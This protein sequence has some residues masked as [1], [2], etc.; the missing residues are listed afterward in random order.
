MSVMASQITSVLIIYLTLWSGTD[1]RKHQSS[2]SLAIMQGIHR[3]PA[4]GQYVENVSIWWH[5][6]GWAPCKEPVMWSFYVFFVLSLNKLLTK[7]LYCQWF[8]TQW[9]SCSIIVVMIWWSPTKK[10]VFLSATVS[11]NHCLGF[12]LKCIIAKHISIINK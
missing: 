9:H 4:K 10:W 8:R 5:H 7:Q 1:Q 2:M 6:H 11:I 3:W 12:E